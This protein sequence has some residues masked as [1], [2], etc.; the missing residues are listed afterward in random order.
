[1]T[2]AAPEL[3]VEALNSIGAEPSVGVK[4]SVNLPAPG[5]L[6]SVARYWS[7]KACL[8]PAIGLVSR[9]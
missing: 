8:P 9:V 4:V 3:E 7:P 1:M 2:R 6:M 5:T